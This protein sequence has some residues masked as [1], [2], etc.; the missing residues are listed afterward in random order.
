M[1]SRGADSEPSG[2][3]LGA[4]AVLAVLS[5]LCYLLVALGG[6]SLHEEGRGGHSRLTLLSLFAAAFACYLLAIRFALRARQDT[7]LLVVIVSA[8]VVFRATLLFTDPIEE[9]DLYRYI[10]DGTATVS[11]VSPFRYSPA[12]V[13]ETHASSDLPPDLK[14]LVTA[15]DRSPVMK[16]VLGRI[17]FAELSTIYPPVSQLV[18]ALATWSTPRDAGLFA[19]MTVMKG[20]F[21]A[22]D[23]GTLALIVALLRRTGIPVGWSVSYGWCP[24]V[25]KEFANSGHL[26]AL[27]VFLTTAALGLAA[28]ALDRN[29]PVKHSVWTATAAWVVLGLAAGAKVYPLVLAPLLFFAYAVRLGRRFALTGF[30]AFGLTVALALWPMLA[31]AL[32][33]TSTATDRRAVQGEEAPPLPPWESFSEP[34]APEPGLTAFAGEWEM[35][36]FLFLILMENLRPYAHLPAREKAWFSVIPEGWRTALAGRVAAWLVVEPW[37]AP[38]VVSRA[39]TLGLFAALALWFAWGARAVDSLGAWLGAAFLTLAWFW[40]LLPTLN[41]WYWTWA[42]PLL[43]FTR[44]RAWLALS[45]LVLLYYVRFWLTYHFAETAVLGTR[46]PGPLFFDYVVTWLEFGPWFLWLTTEACSSRI[47]T[48]SWLP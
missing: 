42:V 20:W 28:T 45:G 1:M 16:T 7:R 10:W 17:H 13:L 9:I 31:P 3:E 47:R 29:R 8:A 19:R 21:V 37:R 15:R 23:L 18:F 43:P 5:W 22:F 27:A 24:L 30:A 38:F 2:R 40:L 4:L 12:Q 6:Q 36:D 14:R 44:N 48:R 46:Y 34:P 41:P 39:L 32:G 33:H 26:D 11:G 35:N 25:L